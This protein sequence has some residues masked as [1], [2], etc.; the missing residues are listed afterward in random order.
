MQQADEFGR[1]GD[2]PLLMVGAVLQAAFL[3]GR[4]VVGPGRA[5]PGGGGSEVDPPPAAFIAGVLLCLGGAEGVGDA[6][7]GGVSLAVDAAAYVRYL[8]F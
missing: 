6:L 8:L 2:G 7:V 3:V 1:D 5:R 4:A